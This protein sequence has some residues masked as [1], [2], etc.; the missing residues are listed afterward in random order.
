MVQSVPPQLNGESSGKVLDWNIPLT[1]D[2]QSVQ[3]QGALYRSKPPSPVPYLALGIVATVGAAIAMWRA[4]IAAAAL[5]LLISAFAFVVSVIEQLS[6]PVAAGRRTSFIVIPLLSALCALVALVRSRSN[7]AFVLKV[8][9][10][11]IMPL[12]IFLNAKA[13]TNARLPGDVA[14]IALRTAVVA[15][16]AT[17]IAFAVIDLPRELRAAAARNAALTRRELL[18]D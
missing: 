2:G 17:V 14:P 12:W 16:A 15:A 8:A 5:L 11:L 6:I 18:E 4:R 10:A 13:L 3:I 1:V 7:Y 9:C